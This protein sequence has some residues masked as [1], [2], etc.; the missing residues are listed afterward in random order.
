MGKCEDLDC[1][2]LDRADV[3]VILIA[4]QIIIEQGIYAMR[5]KGDFMS[6]RMSILFCRYYC[7][8]AVCIELQGGRRLCRIETT[9]WHCRI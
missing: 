6:R 7:K 5:D 2:G 8:H 4:V 9:C 3:D 1:L